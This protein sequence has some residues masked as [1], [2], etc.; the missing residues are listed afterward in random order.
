M[1]KSEVVLNFVNGKGVSPAHN[2]NASE[3]IVPATPRRSSPRP[4]QTTRN[5]IFR[6]PQPIRLHRNRFELS[7]SFCEH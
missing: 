5:Q 7:V 6:R 1:Q 4:R 2:R 3:L